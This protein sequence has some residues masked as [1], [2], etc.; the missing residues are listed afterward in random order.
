[1]DLFAIDDSGQSKPSRDGMKPLRSV[2]GL[3]VPGDKVRALELGLDALC[4]SFG[5]PRG[6]EFKWS[7]DRKSW[8]AQNLK[9]DD[10]DRF[11]LGALSLA[12]DAGASAIVAIT[13]TDCKVGVT[14]AQSHEEAVTLMFLE[15][16]QACLPDGQHAIVLFDKPGGG[17]REETRFLTSTLEALRTGTTYSKLNRLALAVATD[18][19]LSRLLQLADVV[20]ACS[21]SFVAG[22]PT[23]AAKIFTEGVLPLL[24]DDYGCTG[25][26]GL[27]IHPDFRYRNLYHWLLGDTMFVRMQAGYELPDASRWYSTSPDV[28]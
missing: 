1:M 12:R 17:P 5:F 20:T 18:S 8:E 26:R 10:R 11:N 13:D 4:E 24:R 27:K 21:T 19:K 14:G 28:K 2:G 22:E 25:G 15:R 7:P 9:A 3:H 16:A 6:E 23:Y